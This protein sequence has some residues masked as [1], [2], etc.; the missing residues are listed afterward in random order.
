VTNAIYS[1]SINL[2]RSDKMTTKLNGINEAGKDPQTWQDRIDLINAAITDLGTVSAA[3]VVDAASIVTVSGNYKT[4]TAS[5]ASAVATVTA[6]HTLGSVPKVVLATFDAAADAVYASATS[7][8]ITVGAT[9]AAAARVVS[10]G[11]F[12]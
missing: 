11:V 1:Y 7:A 8:V 5:M 6:A 12:K 4:V 3:Q 9:S 2:L 10:I